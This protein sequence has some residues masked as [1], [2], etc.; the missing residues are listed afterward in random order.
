MIITRGFIYRDTY[1]LG[2]SEFGAFADGEIKG[3][4]VG[5]SAG[6]DTVQRQHVGREYRHDGV[7]VPTSP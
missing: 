3:L 6:V 5:A 4:G 1:T 2:D 7:W